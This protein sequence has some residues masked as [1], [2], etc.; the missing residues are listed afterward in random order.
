MLAAYQAFVR[1]EQEHRAHEFTISGIHVWSAIRQSIF[2]RALVNANVTKLFQTRKR[3]GRW[4]LL[5]ALPINLLWRN[6]LLRG[7]RAKYLVVKW[8]R[9][10]KIDGVL[11]DPISR[12]VLAQL[13]PSETLALDAARDDPFPGDGSLSLDALTM[14]ARG[15]AFLFPVRLSDEDRRRIASLES[16]LATEIGAKVE[17]AEWFRSFAGFFRFRRKLLR[18]LIRRRGIKTVFVVVYYGKPD[19]VAAAH[20]AGARVVDMQHGMM[21]KLHLSYDVPEGIAPPYRPDAILLFGEYWKAAT[22]HDPRVWLEVWGAPHIRASIEGAKSLAQSANG[23][24]RRKIVLFLSQPAICNQLLDFAIRFSKLPDAP[25]VLYR[26]HPGDALAEVKH[27]LDADPSDNL[28]I[29]AGGGG[30][31]TLSLQCEA[32]YQVGVFST[33]LLEGAALGS[34]TFVAPL[35]GWSYMAE[36][37]DAGHMTLVPSPENLLKALRAAD[38]TP[39]KFD[40]GLVDAIF[41][42]SQADAIVKLEH[43]FAR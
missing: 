20:D 5:A 29:V 21:S 10:Q 11:Q 23:G 15:L 1:I 28:E 13:P 8:E 26:L 9:L 18:H 36:H 37:I 2:E 22:R 16:A 4:K 40:P 39:P 6:P 19:L 41:G 34:L 43:A 12:Q 3:L 25:R 35:P 27:R 33:A 31:R 38:E 14:L 17:L 7:G 42:G 24:A 32:A 30:A